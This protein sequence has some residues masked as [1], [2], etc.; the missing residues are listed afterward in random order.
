MAVAVKNTTDSQTRTG[1]TSLAV[2]SVMGTIY[3]LGALAVV[4]WGVPYL[5]N[6]SLGSWLANQ[7]LSFVSAAGL[8]LVLVVSLGLLGVLGSALIGPSPPKGLRAGIFTVLAWL[9]VTT[10]L[11]VG[12]GRILESFLSGVPAV[13]LAITAAV[14][15]ALLV[16]G[17]MLL[18]RAT[19]AAKLQAFED[20]GWFSTDRYKQSQGLRVRRATMLG[21]MLLGAAGIYA[22]YNHGML[23]TGATDWVMRVPFTDIRVPVLPDVSITVPLLLAA[24][25]FWL[26]FRV[27]NL[28]VFAD[29]LIATEAEINK[30]SWPTRKSVIQDTVVV[31]VTVLLL[32][33]FLF[34]VDLAWGWILS[35]PVVGVLQVSPQ[36][37]AEQRQAEQ[38]RLKDQIDW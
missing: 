18:T 24:V 4:G 7:G 13:G 15:L 38:L 10:L 20:Q 28:P 37:Q 35:R 19:T 31:L 6:V 3:V 9:V 23:I 11:T 8:I 12:I 30:V 27:V 25:S 14:A 1:M 29:F 36:Q 33:V 16:W 22:L 34:A 21:I 17:W 5:W 32:T 2:S 26:A